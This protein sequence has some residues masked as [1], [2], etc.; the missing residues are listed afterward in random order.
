M[1][2]WV[3]RDEIC[4]PTRAPSNYKE[5]FKWEEGRGSVSHYTRFAIFIV[6][7]FLFRSQLARFV[8]HFWFIYKINIACFL[9]DTIALL[10]VIHWAKSMRLVL[11]CKRVYWIWTMHEFFPTNFPFLD[12]SAHSQFIWFAVHMSM[13]ENGNENNSIT[14]TRNRY[15][16]FTDFNG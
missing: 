4:A 15:P 10:W 9:L 3:K 11:N 13:A 6:S 2:Q 12:E 5:R 1:Q 14:N 8:V 16:H 7:F